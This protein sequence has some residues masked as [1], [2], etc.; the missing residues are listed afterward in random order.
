MGPKSIKDLGFEY[1][2]LLRYCS[3]VLPLFVPPLL[4]FIAQPNMIPIK[5]FKGPTYSC[6]LWSNAVHELDWW[7]N[8]K[9]GFHGVHRV[10]SR[11][12][13]VE[14]KSNM[15]EMQPKITRLKSFTTKPKSRTLNATDLKSD[16]KD[17][18]HQLILHI[19]INTRSTT[20]NNAS[21][22]FA[23]IAAITPSSAV[24]YDCTQT[25]DMHGFFSD[26]QTGASSG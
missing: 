18:L 11:D 8:F 16:D 2:T 12:Q 10:E 7:W 20:L 22:S 6:C 3:L 14:K 1:T 5:K 15:L 4:A 19:A 13:F 17:L 24:P 9:I 23:T 26:T 25:G 21:A